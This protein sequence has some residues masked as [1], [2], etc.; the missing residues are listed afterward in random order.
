MQRGRRKFRGPAFV[1]DDV[2]VWG[3]TAGILDGLFDAAGWSV[4]WD[5][6]REVIPPL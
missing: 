1:V 5:A 6:S 2:L 4:A 3:F